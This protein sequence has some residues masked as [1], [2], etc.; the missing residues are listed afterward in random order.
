LKP[1]KLSI[2]WSSDEGAEIESVTVR[3]TDVNDVEQTKIVTSPGAIATDVK[4]RTQ[5][6]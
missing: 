4:F 5:Y 2:S 1:V 3:Y 6:Y